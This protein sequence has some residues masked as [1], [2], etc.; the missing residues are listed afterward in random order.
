MAFPDQNIILWKKKY[1]CALTWLKPKIYT[2][3]Q[4]ME[5]NDIAKLV[6]IG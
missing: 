3:M 4:T 2:K 1:G 5:G 6:K